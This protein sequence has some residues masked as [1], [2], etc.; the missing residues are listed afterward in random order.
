[1][2]ATAEVEIKTKG[3]WARIGRKKLVLDK[4]LADLG[5]VND[6][7]IRVSMRR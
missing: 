3:L 6:T 1:M 2:A 5:L 7:I 4:S